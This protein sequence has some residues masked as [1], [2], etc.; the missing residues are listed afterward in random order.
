M[1][2]LFYSLVALIIVGCSS[3]STSEKVELVMEIDGMSCSHSCSPFIQKKLTAIEGVVSAAVSFETK[4][5]TVV[6]DNGIVTQEEVVEKVQTIAGGQYKV[7]SCKVNT[8]EK[9]KSPEAA[10]NKD[11]D[12]DISEPEVSATKFKLPN[13]FKI[14]NLLLN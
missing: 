4:L 14:L 3:G 6:I 11:A 5:A 13:F 10:M 1:R 7:T 9:E 2:K 8:L 12:F